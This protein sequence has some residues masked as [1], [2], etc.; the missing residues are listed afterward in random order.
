M[1]KTLL[2]HGF[3]PRFFFGQNASEKVPGFSG[4]YESSRDCR[5]DSGRAQKSF[6]YSFQFR[7]STQDFWAE[8][9]ALKSAKPIWGPLFGAPN[10]RELR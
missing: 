9:V 3:L 4:A 2:S 7:V 5:F 8:L 6:V 1:V 10:N